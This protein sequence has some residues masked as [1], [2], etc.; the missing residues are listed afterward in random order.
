MGVKVRFDDFKIM[1][2][3][4][5]LRA[6]VDDPLAIRRAAFECLARVPT[7]RRIRLIGVKMANLAPLAQGD[8]V[9]TATAGTEYREAADVPATIVAPGTNLPLF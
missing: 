8:L 1:S 5:S 9:R 7:D 6:A 2:R 4:L 3:D